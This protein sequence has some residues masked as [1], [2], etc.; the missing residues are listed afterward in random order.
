[1]V[2]LKRFIKKSSNFAAIINTLTTINYM[3]T[4]SLAI[5]FLGFLMAGCNSISGKQAE[6]GVKNTGE[7]ESGKVEY[8]TYESFIE[9]VWDFEASPQE[10]VYKGDVPSIIDFYADWCAPCRKIAP[11]ME[12]LA[13]DYEGQLKVYKIDV[14]VERKLAGVFQVRSIPAVMFTPKTGQPMMQAGA[15]TEEMYVRIVE[16]ELLGLKKD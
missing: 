10:W 6:S 1:M 11:I 13:K 9:K 7:T 5:L 4:R 14:D 15:L 16:E 12:K 8:L 3:I 2:I